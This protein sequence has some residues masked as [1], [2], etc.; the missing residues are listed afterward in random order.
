M[1]PLNR[2]EQEH[3]LGILDYT[4]QWN[5]QSPKFPDN[6]TLQREISDISTQ[7]ADLED[8]AEASRA[9]DKLDL[10][11]DKEFYEYHQVVEEK[12]G[13]FWECIRLAIQA[14][15]GRKL[16]D[17]SRDELEDLVG[18]ML[19]ELSQECPDVM[20]MNHH[21][22]KIYY[23][24]YDLFV[25]WGLESV[26]FFPEINGTNSFVHDN[27]ADKVTK[28]QW[29]GNYVR[30]TH[31]DETMKL[32]K[33]GIRFSQTSKSDE[34]RLVDYS[35]LS[36]YFKDWKNPEPEEVNLFKMVYPEVQYNVDVIRAGTA[37]C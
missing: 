9:I 21:K 30:F 35:T 14:G 25:A 34:G 28:V 11:V 32:Q 4:P 15:E 36:E 33:A 29:F 3:F 37:R 13:A 6:N 16:E 27:Y 26:V 17:L 7:V 24:F 1:P 2:L 22:R 23:Q 10:N 8:G 18:Q 19:D 20:Y 5:C 31:G 12:M